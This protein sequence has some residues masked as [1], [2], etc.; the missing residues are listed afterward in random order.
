MFKPSKKLQGIGISEIRKM[1][2]LAN[3]DTINLGIGQLPFDPP[4]ALAKAG[5]AAFAGKLKYTENAGLWELRDLVAKEY[6]RKTGKETD[7]DNVIITVGA[8]EALDIAFGTFLDEGDEVLIPEIYFPVYETIPRLYG[9]SVKTYKLG[10][11]FGIDLQDLESQITG[12][13]KLVVINSPANPTGRVLSPGE[14]KQL[15]EILERHKGVYVISDEVYDS[16]YFGEPPESF[17]KYSDRCVVINGI[18]KRSAATGLRLGWSISPKEVT[19]SMLP[20]HQ[21]RV[22]CASLPSQKAAIPVLKGECSCEE[23]HYR[24]V[25][26]ENLEAAYNILSKIPNSKITKPGG[27]FYFFVDISAYGNSRDIAHRILKEQ[28]VLTIP[29]IAFGQSGD[30]YIRI[31]FAANKIDLLEGVEKIRGVL[32]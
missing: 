21:Y 22:T 1:N 4:I 20:L 8:E 17:S 23:D 3:P 9:A 14:L 28:N 30:R 13:T 25:L 11:G 24:K 27:A 29:G 16:L 15:A 6:L 18:S 7:P 31:S 5:A 2:A 12:K 32:Q 26:A 10:E 19:A